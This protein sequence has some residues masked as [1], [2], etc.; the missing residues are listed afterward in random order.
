MSQLGSHISQL[1]PRFNRHGFIT[2]LKIYDGISV[3]I[4]GIL[5]QNVQIAMQRVPCPCGGVS[6][7]DLFRMSQNLNVFFC[8]ML[9]RNTDGVIVGKPEIRHLDVW[10]SQKTEEILGSEIILVCIL[11]FFSVNFPHIELK[12]SLFRPRFDALGLI[13]SLSYLMPS[14]FQNVSAYRSSCWWLR[15]QPR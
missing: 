10:L 13:D 9:P 2:R 11:S 15:T 4:D 8:C 12:H 7:Y 1:V 6:F 14:L 3:A 5:S